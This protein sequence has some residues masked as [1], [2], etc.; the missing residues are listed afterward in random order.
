MVVRSQKAGW[1]MGEYAEL[2]GFGRS[3]LY[4]LPKELQPKSVRVGSRRVVIEP[5]R[6]FLRR[7]AALTSQAAEERLAA[8]TAPLPPRPD[9]VVLLAGGRLWLRSSAVVRVLWTLGFPWSWMGALL[10]C[11]PRPLRD[12]LYG[13]LAANR[14]RLFGRLEHCRV[15]SAVERARFLDADAIREPGGRRDTGLPPGR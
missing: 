1:Q 8:R 15:P 2:V 7:Y 12:A 9:S 11:V 4:T 5:P 14:A 13:W 10:W 3:K 6:A